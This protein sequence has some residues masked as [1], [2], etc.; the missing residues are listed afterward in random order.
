MDHLSASSTSSHTNSTSSTLP[1]NRADAS[2]SAAI[3]E[4]DLDDFSHRL[5]ILTSCTSPK[6]AAQLFNPN[7]DSVSI[8]HNHK[9]ETTSK[10]ASHY[11]HHKPSSPTARHVPT[12]QLFNHRPGLLEREVEGEELQGTYHFING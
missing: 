1:S 9:P 6:H 5:K 11:I 2:A 10:A 12:D 4:A 3:F 7:T 8:S